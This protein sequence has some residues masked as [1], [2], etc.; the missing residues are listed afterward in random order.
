MR[1]VPC[2][3]LRTHR[4]IKLETAVLN[5]GP[6]GV[7]EARAEGGGVDILVA[8]R[9]REAHVAVNLELGAQREGG[10]VGG[11]DG[12]P[13]SHVLPL[14]EGGGAARDCAGGGGVLVEA[15]ECAAVHV[16]RPA[17]CLIE[18]IDERLELRAQAAGKGELVC[19][20]SG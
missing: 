15:L 7:G 1:G 14:V 19:R 9:P 2:I 4:A 3:G 16:A 18:Q 12:L 20:V 13:A 10:G 17:R 6:A 8:K 11:E 5:D